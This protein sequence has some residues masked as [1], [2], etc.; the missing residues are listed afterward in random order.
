MEDVVRHGFDAIGVRVIWEH[1]DVPL[2]DP[3]GRRVH[4][5]LL[6]GTDADRKI[7]K[8]RIGDAVL[9]QTNSPA[10]LTSFVTESWRRP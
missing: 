2:D 4:L 1:S 7:M 9:G 5:R 6:W 3:R 10:R 8:E